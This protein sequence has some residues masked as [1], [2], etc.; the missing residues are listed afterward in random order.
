M[1]LT[2]AFMQQPRG[3]I[4]AEMAAL[5]LLIGVLDLITSYKFRLLPFYAG[6][7]LGWDGFAVRKPGSSLRSCR[8]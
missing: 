6:P 5:L 8:A 7:I 1:N 3:W 2:K 4:A